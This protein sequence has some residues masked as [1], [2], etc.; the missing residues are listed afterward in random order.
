M[1]KLAI[2]GLVA[3]IVGMVP[4][5]ALNS[6]STAC[7]ENCKLN[8]TQKYQFKNEIGKQMKNGRDHQYRNSK[9]H[10]QLEAKIEALKISDPAKYQQIQDL[11]IQIEN[12]RQQI[13]TLRQQN[14][15]ANQFQ[16]QVLRNQIK[17]KRN[18]ILALLGL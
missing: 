8:S 4:I 14:K 17:D 1:K 12:L 16:I 7:S 3:L 11:K 18:Q 13:R 6:N 10:Q 5:Y 2:L 15:T 9:R